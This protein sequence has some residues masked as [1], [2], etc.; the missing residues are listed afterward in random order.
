MRELECVETRDHVAVVVFALTFGAVRLD[1]AQDAAQPVEEGEESADNLGS[2]GDAA[3]AQEAEKIFAGVG[4]GFE[5]RETEKAG[6]ALDGVDGAE[7]FREQAGIGG[8][9]LELG[10]APLHAVEPLLAFEQEFVR[11][12][13]HDCV[14]GRAAGNLRDLIVGPEIF[15]FRSETL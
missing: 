8:A 10:E 5:A 14:I 15:R 11:E 12:V 2:S 13:V 1:G 6:G 7:D 3:V 9:G 4:E